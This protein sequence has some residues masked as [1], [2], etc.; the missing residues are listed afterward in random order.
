MMDSKILI[1]TTVVGATALLFAN[2]KKKKKQCVKSEVTIEAQHLLDS[3]KAE[4]SMLASDVRH[5]CDSLKKVKQKVKWRVK[6]VEVE[7]KDSL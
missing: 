1:F 6:F 3:L 4:N 7:K 2:E 5:E